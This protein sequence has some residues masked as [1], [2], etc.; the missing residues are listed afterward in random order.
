[1]AK[2]AS[3]VAAHY[4]LFRIAHGES[5]AAYR[6]QTSYHQ[7]VHLH[8]NLEANRANL[9]LEKQEQ[10]PAEREAPSLQ[11]HP[12][13]HL[14]QPSNLASL[15][16]SPEAEP[17]Q[18]DVWFQLAV[19]VRARFRGSHVARAD[20]GPAAPQRRGGAPSSEIPCRWP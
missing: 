10:L 7:P 3:V 19:A 15:Q 4:L 6:H 13:P 18:L 2:S 16:R 1:M 14:H 5:M 20:R 11:E 12:L 9:R 17:P 8:P